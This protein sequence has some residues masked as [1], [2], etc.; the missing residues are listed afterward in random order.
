[1]IVG[2][3]PAGSALACLLA[4]AGREVLLLEREAA[5]TDKVC[6]DF[7]SI[8]AL[9]SVAALGLDVHRLGAAPITALRLVHG[10][11]VAET[12][13]PFAALG[14]S[15]RVLD[16]ALLTLAEDRGAKVLR[17]RRALA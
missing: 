17:G 4:G 10:A 5:P 15:R 14:L 12:A 13:L 8:E 11:H 2:G 1:M 3:G 6:G 7:L 16:E 9:R